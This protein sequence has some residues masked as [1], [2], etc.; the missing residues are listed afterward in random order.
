M[1]HRQVRIAFWVVL[2][3]PLLA[4]PPGAAQM[5][6]SADGMPVCN[7]AA[8]QDSPA[9]V[10]DGVGGALFSW[11]NQIVGSNYNIFA[12]RVDAAGTRLW[13]A[14]GVSVCSALFDQYAPSICS[15][16]AGGAIVTWQDVRSTSGESDIYA[17]RVNANGVVQWAAD[18]AP[19]CAAV[20]DQFGPSITSDGQGGAFIVFKDTRNDVENGSSDIYMQH[21]GPDGT[22]LWA[23]DLAIAVSL[24]QDDRDTSMVSDGAGGVV[25]VWVDGRGMSA[26]PSTANDI[27]AQRVGATGSPLWNPTGLPICTAGNYQRYPDCVLDGTNG[28]VICWDDKRNGV[29]Y[30][31]YAQKVSMSGSPLWTA[32]GVV[33]SAGTGSQMVPTMQPDGSGGA[34]VAW[35]DSR[36]G[37]SLSSYDVYAQRVT[38]GGVPAWSAGGVAVCLAAGWQ[39]RV[40]SAP[41]AAGAAFIAWSDNRGDPSNTTYDYDVYAQDL[42]A[43]GVA[44][45]MANGAAACA[46]SGKQE[47]HRMIGDG[48]GTAVIVW[49]DSRVDVNRDIYAQKMGVDAGT[50]VAGIAEGKGYPDGRRIRLEAKLVAAVFDG[51]FY[52]E[53]TDRSSGIRVNAS[54]VTEGQAVDIV[55][56]LDTVAGERVLTNAV[57][58]PLP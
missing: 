20:G 49:Q 47:L 53:E 45:W 54:G 9:L 22:P 24:L 27:Y 10:S 19:V 51:C 6:W 28:V 38:S 12:Q 56:D 2:A 35:V 17:Q 18:G 55:G 34:V 57:V 21:I 5:L 3:V 25:I 33:V 30:D 23:T 58:T 46:A 39:G 1:K 14:N 7:T 29:D 15:D 13:A 16:G 8:G 4:P 41:G 52:A 26:V 48:L 50:P 40:K 11:A 32:N 42:S 36:A 37:T 31:I 43:S 44:Q